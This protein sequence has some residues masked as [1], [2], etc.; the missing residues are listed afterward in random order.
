M[1]LSM[2]CDFRHFSQSYLVL[3]NGITITID[4]AG[5]AYDFGHY[6]ATNKVTREEQVYSCDCKWN[7]DH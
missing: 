2:S 7:V 3:E 1:A 5:Y 4:K 6:T